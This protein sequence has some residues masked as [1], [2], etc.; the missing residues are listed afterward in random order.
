MGLHA[1][2]FTA[3]GEVGKSSTATVTLCLVPGPFGRRSTAASRWSGAQQPGQTSKLT[4]EGYTTLRYL[5]VLG[6]MARGG[7]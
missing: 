4:V 7:F 5:P 6:Q 1:Q 2:S 3:V